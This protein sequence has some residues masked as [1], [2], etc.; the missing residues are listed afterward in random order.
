[1]R[2]VGEALGQWISQFTARRFC[3]DLS[4][5]PEFPLFS[6]QILPKLR[7]ESLLSQSLFEY[8]PL[9]I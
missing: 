1:M 9:A 5:D 6:Q 4:H 8:G 2:G 3:P 7:R